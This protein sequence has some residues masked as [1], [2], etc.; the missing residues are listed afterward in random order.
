MSAQA[1]PPGSLPAPLGGPLRGPLSLRAISRYLE[2]EG[3]ALE[4]AKVL[5]GNP[6]GRIG[7]FQENGLAGGANQGPWICPQNQRDSRW[8]RT[9]PG[10]RVTGP[11][12]HVDGQE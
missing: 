1:G 4:M 10:W 12:M 2:R 9:D 5:S 7:P 11:A 8:A 6:G 3:H